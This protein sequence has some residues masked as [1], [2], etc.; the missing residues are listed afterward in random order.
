MPVSLNRARLSQ[1]ARGAAGVTRVNEPTVQTVDE[2]QHRIAGMSLD[3]FT[4]AYAHPFLV[5]W[6][7]RASNEPFRGSS[8]AEPGTSLPS[9]ASPETA[10]IVQVRKTPA[11]AGFR[12]V[13]IGR[14]ANNDVPL[15]E[16]C[17]SKLHAYLMA[18]DSPAGRWRLV[19]V[20]TYGT[21]VNGEKCDSKITAMLLRYIG[22]ENI[23]GA[24][25][26]FRGMSG[27]TVVYEDVDLISGV[28]VLSDP[29]QNG[30]TID[31][32]TFGETDLGAKTQVFINGESVIDGVDQ[33]LHTSCSTP[34]VAGE[35][36]PLNNPTGA[37]SP[38]WFVV[39]FEDKESSKSSRPHHQ[40]T[41]DCTVCR[42]VM[43]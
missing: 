39:S 43:K 7:P 9:M 20:S 24:T 16:S 8:T 27:P 28:T 40:P 25:V 26:E 14:T 22:G 33:G 19:D 17:I 36:A 21:S 23:P 3:D 2:F 10:R 11:S 31:A 35:P 4:A 34:F 5:E 30:F 12:H 1:G 15:G 13:T 18:P 37:P 41:P 42:A 38:N 32:R 29:S 6:R